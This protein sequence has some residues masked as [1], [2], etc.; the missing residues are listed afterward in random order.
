ME[1]GSIL[2]EELGDAAIDFDMRRAL[3]MITW[4]IYNL[5]KM[6]YIYNRFPQPANTIPQA[7]VIDDTVDVTTDSS[8]LDS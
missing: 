8:F 3:M 1:I 5:N 2:N 6:Y 7:S 4:I